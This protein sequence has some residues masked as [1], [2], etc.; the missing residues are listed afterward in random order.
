VANLFNHTGIAVGL[1][2]AV[3]TGVAAVMLLVRD[4]LFGRRRAVKLARPSITRLPNFDNSGSGPLV[5]LAK[6]VEETGLDIS[7]MAAILLIVMCGILL[8]GCLLLA[9]DEPL[10]GFVGLIAGG[11]LPLLC[12]FWQ[13]ARHLK[14]LQEQLPEAVDLMMR[15]VR[16]GES[17][18]QAFA[19]A[20]EEIPRPLGLELERCARQLDMGLSVA[21]AVRGLARRVPTIETRIFAATMAVHRQ[22]GGNL[23][24]ALERLA[25]VVRDR[26]NYRRQFRAASAGGRMA[27]VLISSVGVLAFLVLLVVQPEY[28]RPFFEQP[29]G[30][31][32]LAVAVSLQVIGLSWIF[33]L[34]RN[35]EQA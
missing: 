35:S 2:V 29:I 33:S 18:D 13:R 12:F 34:L 14:Q 27:A 9:F 15:A 26:L 19:L 31:A 28:L 16:A 30:W 3:A 22:A 7:P 24:V 20:A 4:L 10:A 1:F 25:G 23:A 6:L 21:A 17:L 11:L 5:R 8:G 32:L